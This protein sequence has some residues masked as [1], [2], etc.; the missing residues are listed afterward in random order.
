MYVIEG[1]TVVFNCTSAGFQVPSVDWVYNPSIFNSSEASIV[2]NSSETL[3]TQI[4]N[5]LTYTQLSTLTL[6]SVEISQN[7]TYG[8]FASNDIAANTSS[9]GFLTVVGQL[10]LLWWFHMLFFLLFLYL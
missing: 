1:D 7:G 5:N 8:C 6:V 2:T 3:I 9:I 4:N 10:Y